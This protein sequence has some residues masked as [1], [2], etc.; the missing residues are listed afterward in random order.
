MS[1]KKKS[2]L[3]T[4]GDIYTF[5]TKDERLGIGS[6]GQ[7]LSVDTAAASGMAWVPVKISSS[8][9]TSGVLGSNYGGTGQSS[10]TLGD[11]LMG[12]ST[13]LQKFG[14]GSMGQVLSSDTVSG[15]KWASVK[16]ATSDVTS[17]VFGSNYG[18]TG[19]ST[20]ALGDLL[21]GTTTGWKRV[22]VGS[23][24][25]HLSA[26]T[27][28]GVKWVTGIVTTDIGTTGILGS[29]MGGTGQ[30]S[31]AL[32]DLLAGTTTGWK[33]ITVGAMGN[34]LSAD[35]ANG[36][37]WRPVKIASSDITSGV[38]GGNYGGTG[39]SSYS[40]GDI[41]MGTTTGWKKITV[42]AMGTVLSSD[43][44]AGVAWRAVKIASADITS[45]VI[46][47][48]YG[49]TGQTTTT[50][51]DLLA[52]TATGWQKLAVGSMGQIISVD[53]G[54]ATG[55]KWVAAPASGGTPAGNTTELQY[56]NGGSFGGALQ[57]SWDSGAQRL[58][59]GVT[60]CSN[61]AGTVPGVSLDVAGSFRTVP[62]VLTDAASITLNA[63]LSNVFLVKLGGNRTLA[64]PTKGMFGQKILI[65]VSQDGTGSRK[66]GFGTAY[67]FGTDVPSYDSSTTAGT[68]DYIGMV[69]INPNSVDVVSVSKGYR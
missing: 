5:T 27:V 68:M 61:D 24:G 29:N 62:Y 36:V 1:F 54:A 57:L 8:D 7:V 19:Q 46:G 43:T 67:R 52:A 64:N 55:V 4:K 63:S 12:T 25:Q 6:M 48:N 30:N 47:T 17:G 44:A 16:I 60:N 13:G 66:M 31:Y 50:K 21:V 65:I 26:D 14:V 3:T 38:L 51:G 20:Y 33:R 11:V 32:G 35:T 34:V 42:G 58:S 37:A 15:L 40:L 69:F 2:P 18:G 59:L 22:T 28:T 49:G 10:Y 39:Q 53:T 9:I 23:M 45:G 41:L 56:N